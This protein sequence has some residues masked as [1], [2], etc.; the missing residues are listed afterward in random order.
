VTELEVSVELKKHYE[1]KREK[2]NSFY[3]TVNS[4]LIS[5]ITFF[6]DSGSNSF[7][8]AF[9]YHVVPYIS[10]LININWIY[11]IRA[12]IANVNEI[13]NVIIAIDNKGSGL[14]KH[15]IELNQKNSVSKKEIFMPILFMTTFL[16]Y[17]IINFFF[18]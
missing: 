5:F 4:F 13:H 10:I 9:I 6:K 8:E 17:L 2:V 1:D 16:L 11:V 14:F 15:L 3:I 7:L 12:I 18:G